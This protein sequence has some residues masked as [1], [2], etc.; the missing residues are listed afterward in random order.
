MPK[1]TLRDLFAVVTIV[2]LALGWLTDHLA[3]ASEKQ[4]LARE[5]AKLAAENAELST[6]LFYAG[7][8]LEFWRAGR[9]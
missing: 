6:Q 1:L 9:K 8:M 3:L 5:N 2:A 4:S 7:S